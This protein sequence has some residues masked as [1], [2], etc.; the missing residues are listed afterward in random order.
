LAHQALADH[1]HGKFDEKE[2][3]G[4]I[5][6]ALIHG[7]AGAGWLDCDH[8]LWRHL[9]DHA[10]KTDCVDELI[11]D[12]GYL[13]VADSARLVLALPRVTNAEGRRCADIYNRVVDRLVEQSP[14]D[15]MPLIHM[16]AQMEDPDLSPVLQSPVPPRWRCHWARVQPS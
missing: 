12:P 15:R 13:A 3:Q 10:A 9:A 4:R 8:Y 2:A 14:I 5:V 1:Y 7:I 6:T 11:H 16:T